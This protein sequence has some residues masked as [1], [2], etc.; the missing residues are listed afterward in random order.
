LSK[1][2]ARRLASGF[3]R[4]L[5]NILQQR[6]GIRLES[7]IIPAV[8]TVLVL[9]LV[10]S[11]VWCWWWPHPVTTVY[12]SRHAE[13]LN[14]SNDPPLSQIGV[15]RANALAHVLRDIGIDVVFVTQFMRTQQTGEVTAAQA[16]ISMTEYDASDSL[17]LAN[18]IL[19][20]HKGQK[21]LVIGHSNTLDDIAFGLGVSGVPELT[22]SQFDRLYIIHRFASMTY[23]DELRYG[24]ETP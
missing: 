13:K 14:S 16:G 21:I 12:I 3:H 8:M 11:W 6:K 18:N 15:D 2:E 10:I 4:Y 17:G 5:E 20:N 24:S 22:E 19:A 1:P 23:L 7:R 9:A